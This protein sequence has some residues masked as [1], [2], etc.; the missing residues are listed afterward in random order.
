MNVLLVKPQTEQ[1]EFNVKLRQFITEW[2]AAQQKFFASIPISLAGLLTILPQDLSADFSSSLGDVSCKCQLF[3][4]AGNVVL[5][6]DA[7]TSNFTNVAHASY[8]VVFETVR[9]LIDLLAANFSAHGHDFFSLNSI[10]HMDA[11]DIGSVDAYL[12]QFAQQGAIAAIEP[13]TGITYQ[14]ST[15]ITLVDEDRTWVLHRLVEKSESL[16]SGLFVTTRIFIPTPTVAVFDGLEQL[17]E[18]LHGVADRAVGL[19]R[20][21]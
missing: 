21:R 10:Q 2:P 11:A 15:R 20:E 1:L 14:P 5:R 9:R 4:G 17:V 18:R 3:G 7:L 19:S 13:E 16:D 8:P 6:S 12:G